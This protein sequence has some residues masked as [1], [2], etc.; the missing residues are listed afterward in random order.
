MVVITVEAY[1]D[2]KLHTITVKNKYFFGVKMT[3]VQNKLGLKNL[4]CMVRRE[5]CG[6]LETDNPT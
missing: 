5:T 4:P 3:D 1:K 6:R 2:A